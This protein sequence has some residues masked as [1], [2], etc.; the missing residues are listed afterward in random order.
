VKAPE[1]AAHGETG[2]Q[3]RGTTPASNCVL[4]RAVH[5]EIGARG[6]CSPCG[7]TLEALGS[8]GGTWTRWGDDGG[9]PAAQEPLR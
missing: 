2:Y 7:G 5:R 9:A 3:R 4:T 8:G 1:G 6:G